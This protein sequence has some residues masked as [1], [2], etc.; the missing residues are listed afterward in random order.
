[1]NRLPESIQA[2][3]GHPMCGRE[4]GGLLHAEASLF[5]GARFVL[6]PCDRTTSDALRLAHKLVHSIG[7][8]AIEMDAARHDGIAGIISGLPY[9]LSTALV[10]TADS[11]AQTDSAVWELAASGFRDTSRLAG[12]DPE[13]MTDL[14]LTNRAS[15]LEAISEAQGQ[16]DALADLIRAG[17]ADALREA[18]TQIQAARA[19][20]QE[21]QD[22]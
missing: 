3:G 12:S 6:C 14:L 9:L 1:M 16:L 13:I 10:G 22:S 2:I 15:V 17:D 4:T 8:T 5:Q 19:T 21:Q 18:L 20:W 7:A 11:A